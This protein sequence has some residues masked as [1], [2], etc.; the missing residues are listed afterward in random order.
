MYMEGRYSDLFSWTHPT[1]TKWLAVEVDA[2]AS[3]LFSFVPFAVKLHLA[4]P[5][6]LLSHLSNKSFL[7]SQDFKPLLFARENVAL[8]LNK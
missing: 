4:P 6:S 5:L 1:S 7:L 2:T 3:L 8:K